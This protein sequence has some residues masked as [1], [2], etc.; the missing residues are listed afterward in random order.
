M[1]RLVEMA[2]AGLIAVTTLAAQ[3]TIA[4]TWQG[5]TGGGAA[6]V[7]DLAVKDTTLTGTLTRDGQRTPISDGK[8]SKDTF[9]FKAKLN[10][11][12][13]GL[14]GERAGDDLKVWLDRQGPSRAI[15]LKRV[16]PAAP[17]R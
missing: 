14:S 7:L 13:E 3:S 8:V 11:Q 2:V 4:G 6:I 10:D 17:K 16:K 15:V 1:R 12:P 5:E 9:T